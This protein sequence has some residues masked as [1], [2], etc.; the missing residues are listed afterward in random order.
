[1]AMVRWTRRAMQKSLALSML[2]ILALFFTLNGNPRSIHKLSS[3]LKTKTCNDLF[4]GLF[5]RCRSRNNPSN[6]GIRAS[7]GESTDAVEKDIQ[8]LIRRLKLDDRTGKKGNK[9]TSDVRKETETNAL[10]LM[11]RV[12]ALHAR[13]LQRLRKVQRKS[14]R[15]LQRME[16]EYMEEVARLGR[17]RERLQELQPADDSIAALSSAIASILPS[18]EPDG[19]SISNMLS[20]SLGSH[21]SQTPGTS[22]NNNNNNNNMNNQP[23]DE[24]ARFASLDFTS[25]GWWVACEDCRQQIGG[26]IDMDMKNALSRLQYRCDKTRE[27][28]EA[29]FTTRIREATYAQQRDSL[30]DNLSDFKRELDLRK[31]QLLH[32]TITLYTETK[33]EFLDRVDKLKQEIALRLRKIGEELQSNLESS[34]EVA[35]DKKQK[36]FTKKMLKYSKMMEKEVEK[37]VSELAKQYIAAARRKIAESGGM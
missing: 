36:L 12:R 9:M 7:Y 1:M 16:K 29:L 22:P 32:E 21:G 34:K 11:A 2:C 3:A 25:D 28:V 17:I 33:Q 23:D 10:Y 5:T 13:A 4:W 35:M 31:G 24:K 19:Y 37:Q 26:K 15:I 6:I 18:P 20:P 14:P 27:E 8:E 30:R